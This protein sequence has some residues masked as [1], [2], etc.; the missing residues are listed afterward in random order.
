MFARLRFGLCAVAVTGLTVYSGYAQEPTPPPAP[1][2]PR[3]RAATSRSIYVRRAGGSYL[4]IGVA[5]IDAERAKALKLT[6]VHGVEVKSVDENSPASKAG[7]Q[8]GDVVLEYN[9]QRI[10]GTAQ[11]VRLVHETPANRQVKLQVWS[12]GGPKTLTAAIATRSQVIAGHNPEGDEDFTIEFPSLAPMPPMPPMP[13][14]ASLADLGHALS[15]AHSW[16]LGIECES[17]GSQLAE[18]FGVSEGVLV[19]SVTKSSVAEHAGIRA[20]DVILKIDGE[21]VTSPREITSQ[22]RETAR[23]KRTFSVQVMRDRKPHTLSV[24]LAEGAG[25]RGLSPVFAVGPRV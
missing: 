22:L 15:S 2:A 4:G 11:F 25:L 14:I 17:L 21:A 9:G 23:S 18:Y 13:E 7:L 6:E 19:R 5:E 10:E 20:G 3:P 24:T 8:E 12:N 1:S 16:M